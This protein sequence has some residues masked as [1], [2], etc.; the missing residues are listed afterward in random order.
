M[1]QAKPTL[2]EVAQKMPFEDFVNAADLKT[3]PGL[4]GL[5]IIALKEVFD[6]QGW[7]KPDSNIGAPIGF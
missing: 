7:M 6:T 5:D 1:E 2:R 3:Q 4:H